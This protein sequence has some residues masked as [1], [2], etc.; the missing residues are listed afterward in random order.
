MKYC[1]SYFTDENSESESDSDD[2][3]KGEG[4]HVG[5]GIILLPRG[6][7]SHSHNL[8]SAPSPF[9]LEGNPL[10]SLDLQ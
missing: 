4:G 7:G 10:N 8:K 6:A 5:G 2:R 1:F 9:L 3:F